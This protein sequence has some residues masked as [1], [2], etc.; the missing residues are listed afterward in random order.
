MDGI[1]A[2]TKPRE[3]RE[4]RSEPR[5]VLLRARSVGFVGAV[6]GTP[7]F[8]LPPQLVPRCRVMRPGRPLFAGAGQG[9][10]NDWGS[11]TGVSR[12]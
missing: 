10:R 8:N 3:C 9:E 1:P 2:Q 4:E 7:D 5:C 6:R 12:Q 11:P